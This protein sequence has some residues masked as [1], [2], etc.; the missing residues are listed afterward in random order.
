M[1]VED[2]LQRI[3]ER[4]D[5]LVTHYYET[6]TEAADVHEALQLACRGQ[7]TVEF[8]LGDEK[9]AHKETKERLI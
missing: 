4:G 2:R 9:V 8:A 1:N 7:A 5:E 6:M 3:N